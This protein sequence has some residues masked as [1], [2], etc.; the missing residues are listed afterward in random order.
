ML[1]NLGAYNSKTHLR[2]TILGRTRPLAL[3]MLRN[4]GCSNLAENAPILHHFL[5]R[6]RALARPKL[7]KLGADYANFVLLIRLSGGCFFGVVRKIFPNLDYFRAYP[8][9]SVVHAT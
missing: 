1:R 8:P 6:I 5:E 2:Y 7:R 4:L 9:N 3:S